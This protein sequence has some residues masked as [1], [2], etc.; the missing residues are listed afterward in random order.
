SQVSSNSRASGERMSRLLSSSDSASLS[1]PSRRRLISRSVRSSI[2]LRARP[3][4]NLPVQFGAEQ[5]P[6]PH[7]P[8]FH[9]FDR[10]AHG[11]ADL[12][13][14]PVFQVPQNE[15]LAVERRQLLDGL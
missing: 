9:R 6:R 5:S 3:A 15:W 14:A 7:Q 4:S 8:C 12:G 10:Q 11:L 1:S 13:V 2:I